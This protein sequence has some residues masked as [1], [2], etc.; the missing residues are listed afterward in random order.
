MPKAG[1]V[2]G[3]LVHSLPGG[4]VW[5]VARRPSVLWPAEWRVLRVW[6][7]QW[8]YVC[9]RRRRDQ[10][11][12]TAQ[13]QR[14]AAADR[15]NMDETHHYMGN[16]GDTRARAP[17][18]WWTR[19]SGAADVGRSRASHMSLACTGPFMTARSVP[20]CTSSTRA[21]PRPRIAGSVRRG[22][23]VCRRRA[24][25]SASTSGPTCTRASP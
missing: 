2:L 8:P 1:S 21:H 14:Q 3:H 4:R 17:T 10:A 20:A 18:C 9:S 22:S 23:V 19:G 16:Q 5:P 15:L 6:R 12:S 11:G 7:P 13:A 25:S 24:A